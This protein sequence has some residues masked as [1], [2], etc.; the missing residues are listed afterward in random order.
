[1]E[2]RLMMGAKSSRRASS[3]SVNVGSVSYSSTALRRDNAR[4]RSG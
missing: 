3:D 1:M 2:N 4:M